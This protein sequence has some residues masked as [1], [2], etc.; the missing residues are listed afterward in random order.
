MNNHYH[1]RQLALPLLGKWSIFILLSLH[2]KDMYFAELERTLAGVSRKVLTQNL[3]D[4]LKINTIYKSGTPSTG[5]KVYY[6]LTE[7][8]KNLI[9]LIFQIKE[10]LKENQEYLSDTS[11][12]KA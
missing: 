8:G 1:L 12:Q 5:K 2:E 6:G 10:W 7:L 9:P 11:H 3:N 4:L